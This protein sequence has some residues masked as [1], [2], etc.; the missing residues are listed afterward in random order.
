MPKLEIDL[1]T[2]YRLSAEATAS[3]CDKSRKQIPT[4]PA[5]RQRGMGDDAEMDSEARPS[6]FSTPS[7]K[8][9]Y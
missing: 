6:A 7:L 2:G 5:W 1:P 9:T 4:F 3:G 8:L